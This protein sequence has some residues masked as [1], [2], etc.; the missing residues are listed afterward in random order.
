MASIPPPFRTPI[1][2][3]GTTTTGQTAAVL[4]ASGTKTFQATAV[5]SSGTG[6]FTAEVQ[7][8]MRGTYWDTLG[9]IALTSASTAGM[10]GG[11]TSDDR[12]NFYR[13]NVTAYSSNITP[14]VDMGY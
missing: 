3:S 1:L 11:F 4:G 12:Y 14:T 10:S 9:T 7:G 2:T 13:A 6:N 5:A 8:S